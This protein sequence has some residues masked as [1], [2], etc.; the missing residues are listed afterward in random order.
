MDA[1]ETE[2]GTFLQFFRCEAKNGGCRLIGVT[3]LRAIKAEQNVN[4]PQ[5]VENSLDDSSVPKS[6]SPLVG[7]GG[8]CESSLFR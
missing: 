6:F 1:I 8:E 2:L 3:D 5:V 4:I 7:V